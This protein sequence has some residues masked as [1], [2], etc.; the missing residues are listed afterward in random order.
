MPP[1]TKQLNLALLGAGRIGQVHARTIATRVPSARLVA[2]A[3][4]HEPSARAAAERFGIPRI[5]TDPL[6]LI[7]DPAIDALLI[8]TTTDTHVTFIK[9]AAAAGKHM[10][11]EKPIAL[12]LAQV[13]DALV[14]VRKAGVQCQL[15][16]NRRFDPNFKR[17]KHAITSGEIGTP[18]M[19]HIV[20][21]DPGPPPIAYIKT[22]G[23]MFMDMT[24]HDFDMARFLAAS[25]V[26]SV[27]AQAAV[28]VD[29]AIGE[30]G[31]VDTGLILLRF[32]NGLLATIDNSRK[33]TYGY[34]QRVEV[35]GSGGAIRTENNYPNTALISDGASVRNDLPLNF[36][37]DRY[38]EAYAAE[39][40]A[41]VAA[42]NAGTPVPVNGEDGRAAFVLGLAALR[43]VK[44][45]RPA[46]VSDEG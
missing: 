19:M 37:M 31:D 5:S 18:H 9:A 4:M 28:R 8:C 45:N 10:F 36:F 39:I 13:D 11:C 38:I 21:R 32:E 3:D 24:V 46:K 29:P 15:G 2:V 42:I 25:E 35:F 20:S 6:E 1:V 34:D 41:F 26:E 43:S 14:A 7:N 17:V 27:Y 33:A 40:E 12:T 22:S 16:F 44:E 30:A 23:G